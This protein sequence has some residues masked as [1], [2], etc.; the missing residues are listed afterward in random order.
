VNHSPSSLIHYL[1]RAVRQSQSLIATERAIGSHLKKSLCTQAMIRLECL[2]PYTVIWDLQVVDDA[3]SLLLRLDCPFPEAFDL[4]TVRAIALV[5]QQ[6]L[7]V[8]NWAILG[9]DDR[10]YRVHGSTLEVAA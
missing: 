1:I 2:Y 4:Y 7:G 10:G 8:E 5:L 3:L 6:E 9:S